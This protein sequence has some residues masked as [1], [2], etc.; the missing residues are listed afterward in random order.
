MLLRT[1]KKPQNLKTSKTS[2]IVALALNL[3]N[4]GCV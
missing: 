2:R 4:R 1:K 3:L